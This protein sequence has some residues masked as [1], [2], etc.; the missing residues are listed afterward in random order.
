MSTRNYKQ[1]QNRHQLALLPPSIDEYVSENNS[2]RAID[3]YVDTLDLVSI[4]LK[5]SQPVL[6]TGQPAYHP[7][8]S[9]NRRHSHHGV[10]K[11]LIPLAE[12]LITINVHK[13]K[14]LLGVGV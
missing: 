2:V 6:T 5:N 10:C 13:A 14:Y 11:D 7:G 9:V 12:G 8:N 1:G 4:N 3:A